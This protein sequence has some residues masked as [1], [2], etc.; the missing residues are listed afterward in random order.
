MSSPYD[1]A[2]S[3]H[4]SKEVGL[5]KFVYSNLGFF[6]FV[7]FLVPRSVDINPTARST[8]WVYVLAGSLPEQ[9]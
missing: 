4:R 5:V 2:H 9:Y 8:A 6:C 1:M 7:V 3:L